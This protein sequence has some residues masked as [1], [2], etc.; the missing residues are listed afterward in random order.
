MMPQSE[1]CSS[2]L[3]AAVVFARYAFSRLIGQAGDGDDSERGLPITADDAT[4]GWLAWLLCL[5]ESSKLSGL[6]GLWTIDRELLIEMFRRC[7]AILSM[8]IFSLID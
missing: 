8:G 5:E 7:D 4:L 1:D 6:C 2:V 3:K